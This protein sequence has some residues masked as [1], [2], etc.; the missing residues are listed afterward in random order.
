MI[1]P[2]S[3]APRTSTRAIAAALALALPGL[4]TAPQAASAAP[5]TTSEA[6]APTT[7]EASPDPAADPMPEVS[8]FFRE[9][10]LQRK[11]GHHVQAAD[12]FIAAYERLDDPQR[13]RNARGTAMSKIYDSLLAAYETAESDDAK[14]RHACRLRGLLVDYVDALVEA[15]GGASEGFP[16]VRFGR[17]KLAGLDLTIASYGPP[18]KLCK[19]APSGPAGGG[20]NRRTVPLLSHDS[21]PPESGPSPDPGGD[22]VVGPPQPDPRAERERRRARGMRAGGA[23]LL[24][25]GA[26]LLGTMTAY[27][28]RGAQIGNEGDRIEAALR[29]EMRP[30]TEDE[31]AW[32]EWAKIA[33]PRSDTVAMATGISGGVLVVTGTILTAVGSKR[34]R[35]QQMSVA[36]Q[37]GPHSAGLQVL[38]RF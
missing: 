30:L 32:V 10:E 23:V 24:S 29:D 27:L 25:G 9:G 19:V 17:E 4:L 37:A 16:E 31:R 18:E 22:V 5:A 35:R 14:V 26:V 28:V 13:Y 34:L 8:N 21:R 2:R 15:Y 7:D 38:L 12:L 11:Q 6:G 36:P 33:G 3:L 20:P 1:A